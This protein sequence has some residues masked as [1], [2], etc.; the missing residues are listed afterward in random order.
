MM[1]AT[2][3]LKIFIKKIIT[4]KIVLIRGSLHDREFLFSKFNVK[5][6]MIACLLVVFNVTI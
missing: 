3:D 1:S 6:Y 5:N 2:V 4:I